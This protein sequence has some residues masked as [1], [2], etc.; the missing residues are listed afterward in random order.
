MARNT[1]LVIAF[2]LGCAG[3]V[4]AN[5][6]VTFSLNE[7]I[8]VAGVP[9]VTLG[10]GTY[11]VRT[12][13]STAGMK[14]VQVLSKRQDYVYTTVLTIPAIRP[15]PD[16]RRQFVFAETPSGAPP[17]LHFWFPPGESSG[18]EFLTPRGLFAP[19]P[20]GA[21]GSL[22]V[23]PDRS[24]NAAESGQAAA[25]LY[26]LRDVL[27]QIEKGK[28]GAAR[29]SFRRNYFLA[30]NRE[31][32]MASFLLALLMTDAHE[33]TA[34]LELVNRM[35][36]VR[37]RV[38]SDLGVHAVLESL[39]D[40]RKNLKGSLVRRF[41]LNFAM[42]RIDDTIPRTAVLA[43]ERHTLKGDSFPVE[44]A[45]DRRREDLAASRRR[46]EQWVLAKAQLAKLNDCVK[47][48]LNRVGALQ[49]SATVEARVG[50]SGSVTFRVVL[51]RRR[52][53]DLDAIVELSRRTICGR[54]SSL[55]R[56][57][58]ERNAAVA[59]ELDS[60]RSALRELDRQPGS[61][62]RSRYSSIRN[63]ESAR[64]SDVSRDLM[65]LAE[66][67]NS[68]LMRPSSVFRADSG[69]VQMN[70]AGALARLAEWAG[71]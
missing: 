42:E 65:T 55:E 5:T 8:T 23:R 48:L 1:F 49:Y 57:I 20:A 64:A 17:A 33:A 69:Y 4:G 3:S 61:T 71:L 58:S 67:A 30:Q 60:L 6:P 52:L 36:P 32:A 18:Y 7:P 39:P 14:V 43:F 34:S 63:W 24:P 46:E 53:D 13:D 50:L 47:L 38:M 25:D 51:D 26:A 21:P 2:A 35:D 41:L 10:P 54:H 56:L 40:A 59:R 62:T 45:L 15:Q 28:F 31:G 22:Q 70:I 11:I 12:V 19:Q 68:P 37:A 29:D 66:A 44:L 16:D 9:Q 27:Q